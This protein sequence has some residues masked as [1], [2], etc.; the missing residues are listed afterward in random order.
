MVIDKYDLDMSSYY[1]LNVYVQVD[2]LDLYIFF[3]MRL[4]SNVKDDSLMWH[5]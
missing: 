5:D 2:S 3:N 4:Y 1:I